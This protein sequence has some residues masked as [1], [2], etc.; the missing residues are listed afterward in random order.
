MQLVNSFKLQ[1][2]SVLDKGV[3][4]EKD[5]LIVVENGKGR[6]ERQNLFFFRYES[7]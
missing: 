2:Q 5:F 7:A 6:F 4:L 1:L 3:P